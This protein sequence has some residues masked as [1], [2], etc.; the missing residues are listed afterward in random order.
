MP[1]LLVAFSLVLAACDSAPARLL[2][3][4]DGGASDLSATYDDHAPIPTG[5]GPALEA[6]GLDPAALPPLDQ[7]S[8]QAMPSLMMTFNQS[9]GL[10]CN[11]CHASDYAQ[12]TPRMR[13]ARNMWDRYA[14]GLQFSDGSPLYCD[15]CHQGTATFLS[16]GDPAPDGPMG[17]WMRANYVN[18]LARV[19]GA[20]HD[21]ST[22]HGDPFHADFLDSWAQGDSPDLGPDGAPPD[23]GA[24]PS[25]D[26]GAPDAGHGCAALLACLDACANGDAACA[27][28]CQAAASAGAKKLLKNAQSCANAQCIAV[29]RC[30]SAADDSPDCNACYDNASSG[31]A[32]GVACVP[33]GDPDCGDCAAQWA[34]C[35]RS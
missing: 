13:I 8:D 5:M 30:K 27:T 7:V 34:L 17:H 23:L 16:R 32:T 3:R 20:P 21:C 2:P 18:P 35:E 1:R 25:S 14:R 19:D 6:A 26:A 11:D 12:V 33:P 9:L 4:P 24:E 31:G 15:S 29:G 28:N 10:Q 22:C